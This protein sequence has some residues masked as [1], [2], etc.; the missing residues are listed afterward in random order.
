MLAT[1]SNHSACNPVARAAA[2]FVE[3]Y[4]E[5]TWKK[6]P[7][8]LSVYHSVVQLFWLKWLLYTYDPLTLWSLWVGD[9]S[10]LYIYTPSNLLGYVWLCQFQQFVGRHHDRSSA[11]KKF[12]PPLQFC[13]LVDY[14]EENMILIKPIRNFLS[15][16]FSQ[17]TIISGLHS[18]SFA[19]QNG[20]TW[21]GAVAPVALLRR[22]RR[23]PHCRAASFGAPKDWRPRVRQWGHGTWSS[24]IFICMH[25]YSV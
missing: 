10:G 4:C 22:R 24:R 6:Y 5:E 15:P 19:A 12:C 20:R 17:S 7:G 11:P 3:A 14:A 9:R 13:L 16:H 8:V 1:R 2:Q 25:I 23:C 18:H 21:E